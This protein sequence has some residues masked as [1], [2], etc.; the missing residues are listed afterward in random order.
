[1]NVCSKGD[2][3][4][5]VFFCFITSEVIND[6]FG[7]HQGLVAIMNKSPPPHPQNLERTLDN[8]NLNKEVLIFTTDE[9][10]PS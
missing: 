2:I 8:V 3:E 9:R 10:L 6:G 5:N 4:Y 7:H 1:M